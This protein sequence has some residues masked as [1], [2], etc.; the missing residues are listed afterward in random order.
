MKSDFDLVEWV[1]EALRKLPNGAR[2]EIRQSPEIRSFV[3]TFRWIMGVPVAGKDRIHF[4]TDLCVLASD[5]GY[6]G[7][8]HL[9]YWLEKTLLEIKQIAAGKCTINP[10]GSTQVNGF[11]GVIHARS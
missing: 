11:K 7:K 3:F 4:K 8:M 6:Q 9:D 5:W 1:N 2:F 10:D